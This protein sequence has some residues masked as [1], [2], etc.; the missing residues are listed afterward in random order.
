MIKTLKI[1]LIPNN[2]QKSK[3]FQ[4]AGVARFA[5]NWALGREQENYKN[6]GSFLSDYDLR[7]EFT[8]LKSKKEYKWL[9]DYSNN[10]TKQAIKDACLAYK[11][12]FKGQS[13]FPK[14]KS[15]RKSK[16][17]FYMDTDKIQFTDKTVRLEKITLSR[18]KN[19]Q[20]LNWIRLSERNKIP[21]NG[22]YINPRITFDGISWWISVGIEYADNTQTPVNDGVG[23]DLGIKDL[24]I[25]SDI[26]K[27]YKNIN[28]TQKIRKLKKKKR[29]L[30]RKISRKYLINKKGD[31]YYKTSNIIKAEKKLLKLNHR[32]TDIR[33]NYLH[34]TTTEIINRKPK[35]IV[36]EDLNVKGMM[37]NK[38][39]S[40]V[41]AE[42]CFYEFYR[43][44]EYKSLWNNIKFIIA[45]RF[46]ASSKICSC[47]GAVKKDL[48][49]SD[50][51]Y[52]CD[53]CNTVIDRDKNASINLYNYGKSIA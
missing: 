11:R 21:A 26:D 45:D 24:S 16:P 6:G 46:Y 41:V 28:K 23:I 42:Q 32:L 31:S 44:I 10:I 1:M 25:C 35:F 40:E 12:F 29:R 13:A 14:F 17:S 5:Y 18:K 4:S 3:L 33:H 48:K 47:C 2:K 15:R 49:L 38:Q 51:I 19:K 20:K 52:K 9:N 37:K 50:R 43:Q 8:K 39:L 7:K 34:Q 36:L 53:N 30:Q 22:K 27:P